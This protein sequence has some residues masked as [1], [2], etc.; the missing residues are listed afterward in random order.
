[1][2]LQLLIAQW[3]GK[4]PEGFVRPAR[5]QT[6]LA[7][8]KHK[9]C[10]NKVAT[11]RDG[12][13]ARLPA[14]PRQTRTI[15]QAPPGR[16]GGRRRLPQVRVPQASGGRLP[17]RAVP[18][19]ARYRARAER[20]DPLDAAAIDEFAAQ[21]DRVHKASNPRLRDLAVESGSGDE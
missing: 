5:L 6:G 9:R 2:D 14:L 3:S 16:S 20:Q 17:L 8:C 19:G 18:R 10:R 15:L 11:K 4:L 7:D 12:T 1:M 21:P 13:G